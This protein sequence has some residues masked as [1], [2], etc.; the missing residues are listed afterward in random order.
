MLAYKAWR[1]SRTRFLVSVAA[2]VWGC[3]VVLLIERSVRAQAHP[4]MIYTHYIWSAVYKSNSLRDLYLLLVLTLGL[5]GLLQERVRG[6]VGF[7]L[8][9]PVSRSRLVW[10]RALVG[11][12]EVTLLACLPAVLLPM[13]SSFIGERYPAIQA[14]QFA[15]LWVAGGGV[16]FAIAFVCATQLSGESSAWVASFV[17][18]VLYAALVHLVPAL[19]RVPRLDLFDLMSGSEMPYFRVADAA[20][21]GL[22]WGAVAVLAGITVTILATAALITTRQ[23]FP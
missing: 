2:L 17:I 1:E 18:V 8:A 12:V 7:T 9:L 6:T 10:T 4:P 16:L 5:G 15:V 22:P 19:A 21:V 11:L 3:S 23:E 20:L 14:W 13:G